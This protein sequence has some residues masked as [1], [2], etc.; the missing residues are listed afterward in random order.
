[1]V[2]IARRAATVVLTMWTFATMGAVVASPFVP[3]APGVVGT[4]VLV[5]MWLIAAGAAA[6]GL[7][8]TTSLAAAVAWRSLAAALA[9]AWVTLV[10]AIPSSV[11]APRVEPGVTPPPFPPPYTLGFAFGAVAGLIASFA[12]LR[13]ARRFDA[14]V[15]A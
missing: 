1:M 2:S 13:W 14:E 4:A 11:I 6:A 7:A 15:P 10:V 5:T 8:T 9:L 12:L 3:T